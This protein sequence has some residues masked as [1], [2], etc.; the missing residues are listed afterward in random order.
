VIDMALRFNGETEEEWRGVLDSVDILYG[1][2]CNLV[3]LG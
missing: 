2:W 1:E 3:G